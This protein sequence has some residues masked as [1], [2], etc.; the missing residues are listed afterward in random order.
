MRYEALVMAAL[1]QAS[2][3]SPAFV[4]SVIEGTSQSKKSIAKPAGH[5]P[6]MQR[7]LLADADARDVPDQRLANWTQCPAWYTRV[8]GDR[9]IA[10]FPSEPNHEPM[11]PVPRQSASELSIQVSE[12]H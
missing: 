8:T 3:K 4:G 2:R 5:L 7:A 12:E 11:Q 1:R 9:R 6:S 10:S